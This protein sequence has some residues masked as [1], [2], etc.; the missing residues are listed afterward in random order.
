[1]DAEEYF[2][3]ISPENYEHLDAD[4]SVARI[5]DGGEL[6]VYLI[7]PHLMQNY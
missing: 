2:A 3:F 6:Q 7:N 1:M 5:Q 4:Y